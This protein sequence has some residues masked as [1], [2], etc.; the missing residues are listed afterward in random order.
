MLNNYQMYYLLL[1]LFVFNFFIQGQYDRFLGHRIVN[2]DKI[3]STFTDG[4]ME[5]GHPIKSEN[6]IIGNNDVKTSDGI[7]KRTNKK[8]FNMCKNMN[9]PR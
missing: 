6:E 7:Y 1:C 2:Y 5:L 9:P 4:K 8:H 3:L